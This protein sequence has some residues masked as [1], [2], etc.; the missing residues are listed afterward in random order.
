MNLFFRFFYGVYRI[1]SG[2][3]RWFKRRFTRAGLSVLACL[4]IV[5]GLAP[6]T[7]N[8][9]AYQ[10]FGILF[11]LVV[12]SVLASPPFRARFAVERHLPRF[13]TAGTPFSYSVTVRNL[14]RRRQ[15]GLALLETV[16]GQHPSFQEW[17]DAQIFESRGSFRISR[18][19]RARPFR[20]AKVKPVPVPE[21]GPNQA[22][23]MRVEIT[24]LKR[25]VLRFEAVTLARP[26][27]LGLFCALRKVP[28]LQSVLVLPR[29]Y[30]LPPI[31]LPGVLKYQEG[32]VA[33]ASNVGQS[34]EFVALR[35]YRQGDPLRH[36][37]WRTWARVGKPVVK[38]FEDEFFVRHALVLDTFTRRGSGEAFE[39][40]VSVAASFA[41]TILTQESL[42]DLL[43]VGTQSFCFT[44]GR[45]LAHADQ[46]L[47]ILASV[48][49][50]PEGS[51]EALRTLVL[52]RVRG[53]SG[54]ICVMLSWDKPRQELVRQ[55]QTLGIPVMVMVV[56]EPGEWAGIKAGVMD[57]APDRFHVLEAGQIEEGLAAL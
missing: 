16:A 15:A 21:L 49:P 32:G 18:R 23:D 45:G 17:K 52:N 14:T 5:G 56:V 46:M 40:A 34:E 48:A 11:G 26:D 29:R 37:H 28:A 1:F 47:E 6:D 44:G 2:A 43:F 4:V 25:G 13:G 10:A 35:D 39:E 54:C 30:P 31:A 50:C 20:P 19:H 24:P 7:D 27:P 3:G 57:L 53:V 42:L 36:I 8:N 33:L 22:G 51:F 38:E 41:C 9:I 55:L 12:V